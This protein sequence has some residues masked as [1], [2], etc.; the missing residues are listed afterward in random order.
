MSKVAKKQPSPTL[1]GRP[2]GGGLP[3]RLPGGPT[4]APSHTGR[5]AEQ[6]TDDSEEV[7]QRL[8][9]SLPRERVSQSQRQP[10]IE[11]E[12]KRPEGEERR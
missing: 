3:P 2:G 8:I 5:E 12:R 7:S 11:G 9:R 1:R 6:H 10:E 4:A